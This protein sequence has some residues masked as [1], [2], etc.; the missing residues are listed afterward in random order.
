MCVM[1]CGLRILALL[2]ALARLDNLSH[3]QKARLLDAIFKHAW[4]TEKRLSLYSSLGNHTTT[5][6]LGLLMAGA[7][8]R[9]DPRGRRWIETGIRLLNQ[10]CRHQI[11]DDGG[12][13][14]QSPSYHRF[15]LDVFLL[16]ARFMEA[17]KL[18]D[19]AEI[20]SRLALGETFYHFLSGCGGEPP[21]IGDSDDGHAAA[22]GLHPAGRKNRAEKQPGIKVFEQAGY[23]VIHGRGGEFLTFDHGPLGMAPLYNH[24][25]ADALSVTACLNG[26]PLLV[27]P[28]TYRY[29]GATR[30]RRWFKGTPAHNTVTVDNKDQAEQLTSFIW[31]DGYKVKYKIEN[32]EQERVRISAA[33]DGYQRLSSPISHLRIFSYQ[34]GSCLLIDQFE[35]HGSHSF[36]LNYILHPHVGVEKAGEW[37]RLCHDGQCMFLAVLGRELEIVAKEDEKAWYSKSYG[38][39]EPTLKLTCGERG[40]AASVRF[41]TLM[42][43]GPQ[44]ELGAVLAKF[45]YGN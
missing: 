43:F 15:V 19:C 30:L 10:E 21:L 36:A 40:P 29:N 22:P 31:R 25:H 23:T 35:G 37:L 8:F 45:D 2:L 39:M 1:E 5:E 41:L 34:E 13:V 33:H 18:H 42:H 14:E 17:N 3:D 6:A 12:P 7:V 9:A 11:L 20:E 28:G 32:L 4:L 27:D 26:K 24:G 38:M 44:T 16:A